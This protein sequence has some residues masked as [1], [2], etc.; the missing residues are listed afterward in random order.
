MGEPTV[1][2]ERVG[3]SF[4]RG[5][6]LDGVSTTLTP[7]VTGLLGP[8]G[9]G[10]TTLIRMIAIV[11]EP[12]AGRLELLGHDPGDP[13]RRLAVRRRLGYL[14][15]DLGIDRSFTTFEFVEY[16]AILKEMTDRRARHE[17]VGRVL[18]LVG[19]D[20][21]RDRRIRTL[22]DGM[23]RRVGLAQA[24]L[25]EPDLVVLDEPTAG[26]DA[27]ERRGIRELISAQSAQSGR[28][29]L[30][31]TGLAE[32]VAALCARVLVLREG[33][34]RF[35]GPPDELAAVAAGKVWYGPERVPGARLAQRA[36]DGY[37]RHVGEPPPGV[38]AV[39]PTVEDGYVLLV[40][41][42]Q[43][44]AVPWAPPSR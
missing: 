24:L 36:V 38:D 31:S 27:E 6:A 21:A 18:A 29:V 30:F 43:T 22:T 7:G 20:D 15:K 11:I 12:D 5:A 3:K 10:K 9:S 34:V 2:L 19:L 8:R 25:G 42:G 1:V 26:L 32:D 14:P 39:R 37:H 33:R 23:R 41:S 40:G 4:G 17:E 35:D 13:R 28:T 44:E 16:V